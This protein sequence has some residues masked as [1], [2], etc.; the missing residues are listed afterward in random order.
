MMS[1]RQFLEKSFN[2]LTALSTAAEISLP[3]SIAP[4]RDRSLNNSVEFREARSQVQSAHH[5]FG[6]YS[7]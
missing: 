5:K 7:S 3:K 4:T 2:F 6:K 1:T